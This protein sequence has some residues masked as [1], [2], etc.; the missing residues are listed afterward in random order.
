MAAAALLSLLKAVASGSVTPEKA[1][2]LIA[3]NKGKELS[4]DQLEVVLQWVGTDQLIKS[5]RYHI[6]GIHAFA[7]DPFF[8]Q[9]SF[10][11]SVSGWLQVIS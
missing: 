11:C 7:M 9:L 4:A 10:F 5:S 8:I 1:A 6:S 2:D 3:S